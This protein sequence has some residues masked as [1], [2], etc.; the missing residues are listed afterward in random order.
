MTCYTGS[1]KKEII[2]YKPFVRVSWAEAVSILKE[3][4]QKKYNTNGKMVLK[5]DYGY[6]EV[7]DMYEEPSFVDIEIEK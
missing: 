6:S 3:A 1:M 5:K 7:S 4:L 2:K